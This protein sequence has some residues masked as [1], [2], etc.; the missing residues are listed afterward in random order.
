VV[1]HSSHIQL[2]SSLARLHA[3][4]QKI[5]LPEVGINS[6]LQVGQ[7]FD[8]YRYILKAEYSGGV[9]NQIHIPSIGL[10]R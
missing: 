8:S 7:T 3:S 6:W 1:P 9:P 4:Q 10:D 2:F 5:L